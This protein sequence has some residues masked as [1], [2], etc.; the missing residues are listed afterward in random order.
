MLAR[1]VGTTTSPTTIR[2]GDQMR[3]GK[4]ANADPKIR[5]MRAATTRATSRFCQS[6]AIRTKGKAAKITLPSL[7]CMK[8]EGKS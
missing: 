7:S 4:G 5:I 8:T 2:S 3:P 6:G 1:N